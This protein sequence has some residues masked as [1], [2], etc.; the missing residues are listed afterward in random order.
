[1]NN[2]QINAALERCVVV[3]LAWGVGRGWVAPE[4]A[5]V[6]A[7]GIVALIS[8]AVAIYNNRSKRLAENVAATGMTVIAPAAIAD[9]SKS[10]AVLSASQFTVIPKP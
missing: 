5:A 9:N 7:G 3:F 4:D 2:T 6:Y 8:A 10:T 1:V